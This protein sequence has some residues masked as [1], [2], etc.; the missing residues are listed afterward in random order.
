MLKATPLA[1]E[2]VIIILGARRRRRDVARRC[3]DGTFF[4]GEIERLH[5]GSPAALNERLSL[6]L[7]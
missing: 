4:P 7:V 2:V 3:S 5:G 1:H 6:T